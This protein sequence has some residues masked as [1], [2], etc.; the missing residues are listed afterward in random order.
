MG[1]MCGEGG[2]CPALPV[3]AG[4]HAQM[5]SAMLSRVASRRVGSAHICRSVARRRTTVAL[6]TT[7]STSTSSSSQSCSAREIAVVVSR[8]LAT[9]KFCGRGLG[10]EALVSA[11]SETDQ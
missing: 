10:L 4:L 9:A 11:V 3:A 6:A 2:K 5:S 7:T 1:Q 8:P